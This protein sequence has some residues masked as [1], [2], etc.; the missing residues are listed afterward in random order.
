MVTSTAERRTR[1]TYQD[2]LDAPVHR[3][4]EIVDGTLYINPRPQTS[5]SSLSLQFPPRIKAVNAA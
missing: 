3:V 2:V 4:A 1:T 5:S